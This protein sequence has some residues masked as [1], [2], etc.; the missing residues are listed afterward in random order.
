MKQKIEPKTLKG[1]YDYFAKDMDIRNFVKDLFRQTAI[2]Y[3]FEALETP[4]LEYSELILG[5]SGDEAEKL[6][7]RFKD[8]GGR[9]VM[10]KYELM[11]PMCRAVAQ[12]YNNIA[13]PYK[14]YQIQNAWRAENVQR[15][16][17]REFTQMDVDILGSDSP[18]ADAEVIKFGL[19]FL[20]ELGFSKYVVL[21]NNRDII[22][23]LMEVYDIEI[24]YFEDVYIAIDKIKK[25]SKEAVKE[26][27]VRKGVE[28]KK[29]E[30]LLSSLSLN[31]DELSEILKES[32]KGSRGVENVKAI[33][34]IVTIEKE[35]VNFISFD[36]SLTR[37]LASYTG[38]VWEY[39][40]LDGSVGSVSGGGRYDKAVSKYI[41]KE[42]PA[43]GTSFGLERLTEIIKERG[44]FQDYSTEKSILL[45]PMSEK[46][47]GYTIDISN[48][49]RAKKINTSI[50][51]DIQ[52]LKVSLKY[53]DKKG[54]KWVGIIGENEIEKGMIQLKN[55][56]AKTEETL[57]PEKVISTIS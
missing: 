39:E 55:M 30:K 38:P 46:C 22:K 3:G 34:D 36:P 17:L 51:P 33:I 57:T 54:Y 41:N 27:V 45:I 48:K 19:T 4:N 12:N 49:F 11:I 53:A 42:I 1:F 31:I 50:Y 52:K 5:Q 6:Y 25:I 13:F 43:T 40:I 10:L 9:D 28:E 56:S 47:I 14:R 29:T 18:I 23:G 21:I 26:E 7:Y 15:G 44:M 32:E 8:N 37:G 24:E 16:R 20:R 35:L 2:L